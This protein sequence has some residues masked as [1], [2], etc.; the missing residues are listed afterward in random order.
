MKTLS[1]SSV[2]DLGGIRPRLRPDVRFTVQEPGGERSCV[3]EDPVRSQYHRLG[4]AEYGLL[5]AMDGERT[6]SELFAL[7]AAGAGVHSLTERQA[8]SLLGWGVE[9]RLV[10]LGGQVPDARL[11]D[12]AAR[13]GTQRVV[14]SL[15]LLAL[16]LPLGNPSGLLRRALPWTDWLCSR[17][18]F[19]FWLGMMLTAGMTLRFHWTRWT[20]A[21]DGVLAPGNWLGLVTVYVIIKVWHEFWHAL[22]CA[23]Y[24]GEVREAG[25]LLILLMPLGYVDA[26]SSL[27]FRSRWKRFAVA[28]AGMY[29]ELLLAAAGVLV[30]AGTP[31]GLV[32]TLARNTVITAGVVTLFFNLNP[33]M[34]FDGYHMLC[35]GLDLPNLATR[36][37][38]R[39]REGLVWLFFG[40][41]PDAVDSLPKREWGISLVYAVAAG[42]WRVMILF[43]LLLAASRMF[44]GGGLVF[45]VMAA[46]FSLV[47]M[48][49]QQGSGFW[50]AVRGASPGGR[51]RAV[52]L[53]A[54]LVLLLAVPVRSRVRAPAVFRYGSEEVHRAEVPGFVAEVTVRDGEGVEPGAELLRLENPEAAARLAR[55][56]LEAARQ[57]LQVARVRVEG[58]PA[59]LQAEEAVLRGF[60][61]QIEDLTPKVEGLRFRTGAGGQ[62]VGR[63]LEE[64][65]G[66]YVQRGREILR[67]VRPGSG[68]LVLPVPGPDVER[69]RRGVGGRVEVFRP[70]SGGVFAGR[71]RN[72]AGRAVTE[73]LQP[74]VTQLAGGP[75]AVRQGGEGR[76]ELL[77]PVFWAV[78]EPGET[79][80]PGMRSGEVLRVRMRD[81]EGVP[82]GRRLVE[83]MY[84]TVD[85][86]IDRAVRR[87]EG[88]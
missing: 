18:F 51:V 75:L 73:I 79:P 26:S 25:V 61:Q 46:G 4:M 12:A 9:Q 6:F 42:L 68:E 7:A 54:G 17:L 56:R 14:N 57:R 38:L 86:W 31:E 72:V 83:G 36:A 45:A 8:V 39:L 67:V 66:L 20:G 64:L 50:K 48:A 5:R 59:A 84:R 70:G 69:W 65:P 76:P 41:R 44:R 35:D 21:V 47:P 60:E 11:A 85:R 80:W 53:V 81:A 52:L 33:L 23:H 2:R 63:N 16:R 71:L 78:V 34:R 1:V 10:D 29:G 49:R 19:V 88:S 87:V 27:T 58:R 15:N 55:L 40:E 30:W 3:L 28:A 32:N 74:E 62:V 77:A 82:L 24:G 22:V 43:T 37:R 13:R